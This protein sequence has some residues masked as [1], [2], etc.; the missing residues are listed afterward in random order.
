MSSSSL[1]Y[2]G[3]R[4]A[5]LPAMESGLIIGSALRGGITGKDSVCNKCR[6]AECSR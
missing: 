5:R 3:E 4:C 2:D 1:S 6:S